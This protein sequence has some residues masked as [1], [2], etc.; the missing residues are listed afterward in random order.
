[1]FTLLNKN[2]VVGDLTVCPW[3]DSVNSVSLRD[4]EVITI[5]LSSQN[6][7]KMEK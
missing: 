3:I 2:K 5:I 6:C 7:L 4:D 1:M